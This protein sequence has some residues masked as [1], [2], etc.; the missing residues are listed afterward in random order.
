MVLYDCK[1]KSVNELFI[2]FMFLSIDK[3]ESVS[4]TYYYECKR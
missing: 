2:K 4:Y 3:Q 1:N